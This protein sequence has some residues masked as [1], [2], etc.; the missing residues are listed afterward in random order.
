MPSLEGVTMDSTVN[1]FDFESTLIADQP[2][3]E[4]YF[5]VNSISILFQDLTTSSLRRAH[6]T[7]NSKDARVLSGRQWY[8]S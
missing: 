2:G 1:G 5:Y 6:V 8:I 3:E 7:I 4:D